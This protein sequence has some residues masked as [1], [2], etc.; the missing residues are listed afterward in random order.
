MEKVQKISEKSKLYEFFYTD[1]NC[2]N[3]I[4][5]FHNFSVTARC[6]SFKINNKFVFDFNFFQMNILNQ[7]SK[8][9]GLDHFI[10][11]LIYIDKFTSFLKF[12]YEE[13]NTM[14]YGAYKYLAKHDPNKNASQTCLRMKEI[15]KDI[16]NITITFPFLE[17]V[18][19]DDQNYQNCFESDYNNVVVNG[20]P[21]NVLDELNQ[22]D[23]KEWPN[24]LINMKL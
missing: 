13:L 2:S 3:Y 24:I 22:K 12:G 7:I 4:K 10:K 20:I 9:Q 21:L 8:I 6:K 16:I 23:F 19:F 18:R 15:Y 5:I 11:K 1:K 17:T 14:A